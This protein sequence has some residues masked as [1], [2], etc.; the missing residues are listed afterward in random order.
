M[1][2][3]LRWGEVGR[4]FAIRWGEHHISQRNGP[5]VGLKIGRGPKVVQV[6]NVCTID[7]PYAIVRKQTRYDQAIADN[8]QVGVGIGRSAICSQQLTALRKN[9]RNNNI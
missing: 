5:P 6:G 2:N 1:K 9:C 7:V 8:K 3:Y 4:V